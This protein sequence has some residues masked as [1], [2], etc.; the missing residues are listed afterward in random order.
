MAIL[1]SIN[2][3]LTDD[4]SLSKILGHSPCVFQLNYFNILH[5]ILCRENQVKNFFKNFVK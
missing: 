5:S 1:K 2:K 3:V 4:V